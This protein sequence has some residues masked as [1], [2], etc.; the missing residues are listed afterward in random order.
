MLHS[1]I[2]QVAK[3]FCVN[4]KDRLLLLILSYNWAPLRS[5]S[6]R[7]GKQNQIRVIQ[8]KWFHVIV[9]S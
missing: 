9:D 8:S 5:R 3:P 6:D 2:S 1:M 4:L 7:T